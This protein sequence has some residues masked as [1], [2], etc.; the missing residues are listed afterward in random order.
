MCT[1]GSPSLIYQVNH[2]TATST[3]IGNSINMHSCGG[4]AEDPL[5]GTLYAV[6]GSVSNGNGFAFFSVNKLTGVAT[7]IGAGT[8][9]S[10]CPGGGAVNTDLEFRFPG[11]NALFGGVTSGDASCI[12]TINKATGVRTLVG[13]TAP[14]E[15]PFGVGVGAGLVFSVNATFLYYTHRDN[16]T[17]ADQIDGH[18]T[19]INKLTG[20]ANGAPGSIIRGLTRLYT[21]PAYNFT[22]FGIDEFVGAP[23]AFILTTLD[24]NTGILIPVGSC[25]VSISSGLASVTVPGS[26]TC[27]NGGT[28]SSNPLVTAASGCI[29]V[30]GY[31]GDIC[32][33]NIDECASQPCK[34]GGTCTDSVNGFTCICVAGYIGVFCETDINECASNPCKN[35]G[36]CQDGINGYNCLCVPGFFGVICETNIDECASNPCKNGGTCTDHVNHFIC[37]CL[38]GYS[39]AQ[40][41]T[42]I[43]ECASN[44]CE[45]G[46][47]CTDHVNG[48]SCE[49]PPN[50]A[51]VTCNN[52]CA[53]SPC[54][55]S[56][57]CTPCP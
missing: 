7:Q 17:I 3:L 33:T 45:N 42:D 44:P 55:N 22:V 36:T 5:T 35:G 16:L 38:S 41:E 54:Q 1:S 48:F 34:N 52:P 15:Q 4:I 31:S 10:P 32:Q 24:L 21:P 49:C 47:T 43:D 40:C 20:F 50:T 13:T 57:S 11:D 27:L 26:G 23:P 53:S 6:G 29:C 14:I 46:G 51:G 56:G 2:H 8:A 30:S 28:C 12:F 19:T 9:V 37:Q 39:G 25:G 18:A